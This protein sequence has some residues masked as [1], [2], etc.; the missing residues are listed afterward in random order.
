MQSGSPLL[1]VT[2]TA[3]LCAWKG[4]GFGFASTTCFSSRAAPV[5]ESV[6]QLVS[7]HMSGSVSRNLSK[8]TE[9]SQH[10]CAC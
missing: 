1:G 4:R 2:A 7:R 5:E 8:R 3:A 10:F 9:L 6:D